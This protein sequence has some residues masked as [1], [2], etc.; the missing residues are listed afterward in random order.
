[1]EQPVPARRTDSRRGLHRDTASGAD[2]A[3]ADCRRAAT[4]DTRAYFGQGPGGALVKAGD[5]LRNPAYADFLRRLAEQDIAALYTG[6]TAAKIVERTRAGPLGGSMTTGGSRCLQAD[7]AHGLVCTVAQLS[8]LRRRR[9]RP[10]ASG[11]CN[12]SKCLSA[13]ISLA[14]GPTDPQAWYLFAEASRLMYADRDK[15]VGD[16]A[17]VGVPVER[18][19]RPRYLDQ[20]A[21]ADR[22]QPPDR[23]RSRARPRGAPAFARRPLPSKSPAPHTSSLAMRPA[24][25]SA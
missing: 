1:M 4:P 7:Q 2:G 13:P 10:A 21:Q 12:F 17:F 19:A 11:C 22:S 23:R 18:L 14:A 15:Y 24:T 16:P 8:R 20:R 6:S 25:S 9:R 3:A 5:R